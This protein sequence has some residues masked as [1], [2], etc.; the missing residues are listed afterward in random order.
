MAK[1]NAPIISGVGVPKIE[2]RN[3]S[4]RHNHIHTSHHSHQ[5][6]TEDTAKDSE[7]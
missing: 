3:A 4:S 2:I 6:T 5:Y 1:R 7:E